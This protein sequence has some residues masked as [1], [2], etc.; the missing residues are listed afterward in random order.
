MNH[1]R[2]EGDLACMTRD[3]TRHHRHLT[4]TATV[5]THRTQWNVVTYAADDATGSV[6]LRVGERGGGK[7]DRVGCA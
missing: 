5:P 7:L 2:K 6:S 1:R 3:P 4:S